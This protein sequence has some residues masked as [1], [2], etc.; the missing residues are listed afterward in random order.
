[1]EAL[2]ELLGAQEATMFKYVLA[3][4][5]A[6]GLYAAGVERGIELKERKLKRLKKFKTKKLKK[7]ARRA[8]EV[9][10]P[11]TNGQ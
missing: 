8:A 3:G 2:N 5:V 9:S 1:M 6:A 10:M 11:T 4:V 7:R